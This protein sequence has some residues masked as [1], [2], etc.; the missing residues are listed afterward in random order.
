MHIRNHKTAIY[1]V[2]LIL[3]WGFSW[4]VLKI[5]LND[6]PPILFAGLRTGL[7]GLIL[8][9]L[10]VLQSRKMNLKKLW[11]VYLISSIFNAIFFF[12]LQTIALNHL[13][14]GLLSVLVYL[15]PIL[16]GILAWFWLGEELNSRKVAGLLLGFL[17]VAAI[18]ARGMT[19]HISTFGVVL[20]LLSAISWAIG[21]VYWK[22]V[23]GQA[24][25][26]WLV[27]LPFTFGG[28]VLI[29]VGLISESFTQIHFTGEFVAS[30]TYS[31]LIATGVSWALWL[32]LVH[33]GEVSKV[34]SWTFFVPLLSVLI[35]AI[36][37]HETITVFLV[38]GLV[39]IVSGIYL[40]NHTPAK[41]TIHDES[42]RITLHR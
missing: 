5:G 40:V 24:D 12:G 2:G 30:L 8:V 27:A 25:P 28:I 20:A 14:S 13:P 11:P 33:M 10:A 15:E 38:I 17:G 29:S 42:S 23:Q 9:L 7:G 16:V 39:A 26:L 19:G 32:H 6:S 35:G 31:F 37:L 34:A 21:T 18:S 3:M 4:P 22:R 41:K 36:W 1:T